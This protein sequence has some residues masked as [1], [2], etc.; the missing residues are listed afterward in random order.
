MSP[1]LKTAEKGPLFTDVGNGR[2][3]HEAQVQGI[4][5]NVA[6]IID[7]DGDA[8]ERRD[9]EEDKVAVRLQDHVEL[10]KGGFASAALEAGV[11]EDRR[12]S[13]AAQRSRVAELARAF[14]H[15]DRQV[16]REM[17]GMKGTPCRGRR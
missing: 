6:V 12:G 9:R 5:A 10:G 14:L 11:E 13:D 8:V 3:V 15:R 16:S 4:P 17:G 2:I 1:G 7:L